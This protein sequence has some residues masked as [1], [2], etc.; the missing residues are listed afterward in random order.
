LRKGRAE[1]LNLLA[2]MIESVQQESKEQYEFSYV[3]DSGEEAL[4]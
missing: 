1:N 4:L 2:W 3:G